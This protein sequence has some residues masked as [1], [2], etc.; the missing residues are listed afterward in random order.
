V[1]NGFRIGV[2][3]GVSYGLFGDPD[4]FVCQA[5][6][7]GAVVIR[8]YLYWSQIE[9]EAGRFDFTVVDHLL[10]QLTVT[11]SSNPNGATGPAPLATPQARPEASSR[12]RPEVWLTVCSASPWATR[13]STTFQ[14]Q[15]PPHDLDVYRRFLTEL[16]RHC[17]D[18]VAVWQCNNEPSNSGLLWSGTPEEYLDQLA[19]FHDVVS[20]EAPAAQ[21]ALGGCGYDVL[22]SPAGSPERTFF[23][24]LARC[25]RDLFDLFPVHLYDDVA[26]ALD[27]IETGRS[28]MRRHGY[29]KPVVVGEYSGPSM[30]QFPQVGAALGEVMTPA[31]TSP[32]PDETPDRT[33]MRLL[34]DR[35]DEWPDTVRM[36]LEDPPTRLLNLRERIA[37][38]QVV[39]RNVLA[40]SVGVPLTLCWN[41]APEIG[42]YR[43]RLNML[44]FLSGTFALMDYTDGR[45]AVEH[46]RA[47]ALRRTAMWLTGA[48]GATQL[49]APD[50]LNVYDVH[51]R[52][53]TGPMQVIWRDGDPVAGDAEEATVVDHPWPHGSAVV[54]DPFGA[55]HQL[56]PS[57]RHLRLPTTV[58]PWVVHT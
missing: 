11:S 16:V 40:L 5:A 8:V 18:R 27:H 19:V 57:R 25:G 54:E 58:T 43:D 3:R 14:P 15:S 10:D 34:Y 4:P 44:G 22:S 17:G 1:T 26:M 42:G 21:V 45:I 39:T 55:R 46:S 35:L 47:A 24:T 50:G 30:F 31:F 37:C 33:A 48:T 49:K 36:F 52:A 23:D 32:R 29:E 6:A 53:G 38:R 13:V 2:V 51:T 20:R 56:T 12:V 41:L 28:F 9:P 7:L